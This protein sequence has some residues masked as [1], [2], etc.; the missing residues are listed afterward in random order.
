M[1]AHSSEEGKCFRDDSNKLTQMEISIQKN[2]KLTFEVFGRADL[3]N[4]S[5][6][7]PLVPPE[8]ALE[9][10]HGHS[11]CGVRIQAVQDCS[12]PS[13]YNAGLL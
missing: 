8:D 2:S 9:H 5:K 7:P 11:S 12:R 3:T 1:S 4:Q 6:F 10:R 13:Q